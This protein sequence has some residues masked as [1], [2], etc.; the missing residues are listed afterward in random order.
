MKSS[1]HL[2]GIYRKQ[3]YYYLI[4]SI[5]N[6]NIFLQQQIFNLRST[7]MIMYFQIFHERL[8]MIVPLHFSC[9]RRELWDA[10]A[11]KDIITGINDQDMRP[12]SRWWPT[13][14]P[15]VTENSSFIHV[16]IGDISYFNLRKYNGI[17]STQQI[18]NRVYLH[19][20]WYSD[21]DK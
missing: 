15:D 2:R 13:H 12:L 20:Q 11:L 1:K 4:F 8:H 9:W 10:L 14:L 18:L 17:T 6:L 16:I 21:V 7:S 19:Q 3:K 5:L